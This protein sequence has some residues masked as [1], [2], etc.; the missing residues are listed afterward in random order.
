MIPSFDMKQHYVSYHISYIYIVS[1]VNHLNILMQYSRHYLKQLIQLEKITRWTKINKDNQ[2]VL[3]NG[4]GRNLNVI[5]WYFYGEFRS[6]LCKDFKLGYYVKTLFVRFDTRELHTN[7]VSLIIQCLFLKC[8]S[9]P[10]SMR[11]NILKE[12]VLQ[13]SNTRPFSLAY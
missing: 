11:I 6:T 4:K 2:F 9:F 3:F 10:K 12:N 1:Y 13:A 5:S 8:C 7:F